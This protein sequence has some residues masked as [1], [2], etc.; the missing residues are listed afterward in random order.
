MLLKKQLTPEPL[1]ALSHVGPVC[2]EWMDELKGTFK[3]F[4]LFMALFGD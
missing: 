1:P 4:P 2:V 3:L